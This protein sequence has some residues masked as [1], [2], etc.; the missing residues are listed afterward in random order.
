MASCSAAGSIRGWKDLARLAELRVDHVLLQLD[1]DLPATL[2]T[3]ARFAELRPVGH[4]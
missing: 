4:G 3:L 2:A 1:A